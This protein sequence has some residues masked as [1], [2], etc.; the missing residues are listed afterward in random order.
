MCCVGVPVTSH[1]LSFRFI[2]QSLRPHRASHSVPPRSAREARSEQS[3]LSQMCNKPVRR[4]G[5]R[6]SSALPSPPPPPP[7]ACSQD[8]PLREQRTAA[9]DGHGMPVW[10]GG[11]LG[12]AGTPAMQAR[13][14]VLRTLRASSRLC[15]VLRAGPG[16]VYR[17]QE[18]IH[19][20]S[21]D[22]IDFTVWVQTSHFS[23]LKQ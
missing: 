6:C 10:V 12:G 4:A 17:G 16:P 1:V 22:T 21:T 15:Y 3:C 18:F 9:R 2:D 23:G 19:S 7:L 8:G 5:R 11:W 14:L 13:R 20:K